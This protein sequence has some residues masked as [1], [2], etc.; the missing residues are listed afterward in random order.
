MLK[1]QFCRTVEHYYVRED[2]SEEY[3]ERDN[4]PG[5]FP[6]NEPCTVLWKGLL[7]AQCRMRQMEKVLVFAG[8]FTSGNRH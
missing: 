3:A 2:W 4:Y 6:F 8:I 1:R 5:Y 7:R